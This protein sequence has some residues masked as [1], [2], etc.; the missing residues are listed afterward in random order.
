MTKNQEIKMQLIKELAHVE[1]PVRVCR[2]AYKF[3]K[4]NEG[5]EKQDPLEDY[6]DIHVHLVNGVYIVYSDDSFKIYEEGHTSLEDVKMI[7]IVYDGHSFGIPLDGSYGKQRLLKKD[8]YPKDEYC[9]CE[10]EALA[11]WDFV[12]HTNHLKRLGLAFEIK[13]GHY[14]PTAPV[15]IAIYKCRDTINKILQQLNATPI[16]FEEDYWFAQRC[17]VSGAWS[18]VG[19]IGILNHGY[20]NGGYQVQAVTLWNVLYRP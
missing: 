14:L 11:D 3:L 4:E 7:G 16:D 18:F 8:S 15:W 2:E 10:C 19:S 9:Q 20:V 5:E 17:G 1:N 13:D 12:K 6:N